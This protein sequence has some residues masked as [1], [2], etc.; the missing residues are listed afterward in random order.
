MKKVNY[1]IENNIEK[2]LRGE[3]TDFLLPLEVK[4][5]I[6]KLKKK[7]Y[8]TYIPYPEADKVILYV[9]EKPEIS[10]FKINCNNHLRHQDILGALFNQGINNNSF[11]DIVIDKHNYYFY[12]LPKLDDFIINNFTKI[13]KYN[14]SLTKID[15]NYLNDFQKPYEI[16][17]IIVPSLRLDAVLSCVIKRSRK[18]VSELIDN[19]KVIINYE[20]TTKKTYIL[21]EDDIFSIHK[22]GKYKFIEVKKTTKK[23]RLVVEYIKYI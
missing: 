10:L 9:K 12:L 8:K 23:D 16:N 13:A 1:L 11:G 3:E 19:K 15:T 20:V 22:Y 4:L 18:E 7:G 2:L 14:I 6:S 5:I 17:K 21:K